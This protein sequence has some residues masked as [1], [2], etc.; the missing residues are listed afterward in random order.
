M[1]QTLVDTALTLCDAGSAGISLREQD[2]DQSG[3]FRWVAV[4]GRCAQLQGHLIPGDD[5]P[6]GVALELGSPQLFAFPKR[7]FD[8]L[9]FVGA[10]VT[11]E[12]VVPVPG[13]PGPFGALWVMSH[14][15]NHHFD[16]EHRRILASL[17]DFTC[18]ALTLT[19]ARADAEARAEE[20]E[21]AR[22]ALATG[23]ARK[24]DFITT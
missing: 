3:A 16:G 1:L 11:E 5:S 14:D 12:L 24:D 13:T 18:A 20:A 17:A 4:S 19:R 9:S 2:D 23:E 22:H 21:A 15:A 10:E 8:C 7:Q 6:A